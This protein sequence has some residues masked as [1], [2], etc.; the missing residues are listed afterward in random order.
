MG[1]IFGQKGPFTGHH[2][3]WTLCGSF[4]LDGAG[5]I[6]SQVPSTASNWFTVSKP[7]GTGIYRVTFGQ[8]WGALLYAD[9]YI[10]KAAGTF[11]G[12]IMPVTE[13]ATNVGF[14]D[15]IE[16]QARKSSDG[17]ALA[18][19]SVTVRFK[20]DIQNTTAAP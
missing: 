17:T 1:D 18:I 2:S 15:Y 4:V 11:D 7:A 6:T 16:F 8:Q 14:I 19:V 5:A 10:L 12:D 13:H 9:A 3:H 20:I